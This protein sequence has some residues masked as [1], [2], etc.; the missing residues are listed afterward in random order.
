MKENDRLN[1]FAELV[2]AK[3][4]NFLEKFNSLKANKRSLDRSAE[5]AISVLD[6]LKEKKWSQKDFA[7]KMGVSPQYVNKIV[8]GKEN[9]TFDTIDK[10]EDVLECKLVSVIDYSKKIVSHELT[11]K[12]AVNTKEFESN[13]ELNNTS[14]NST[15][16]E[17][18]LKI[19][20]SKLKEKKFRLD[21]DN[22]EEILEEM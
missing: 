1:K 17:F 21:N 14:C 20:H 19:V 4:S 6:K 5:I 2:S 16:S 11:N 3:P 13:L 18:I 8:K 12:G 10:L 22:Y 7:E 15:R 9:L